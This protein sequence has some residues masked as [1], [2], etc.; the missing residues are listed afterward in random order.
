MNSQIKINTILAKGF[1]KEKEKDEYSL[2]NI[3]KEIRKK[4][5]KEKELWL[6]IIIKVHKNFSGTAKIGADLISYGQEQKKLG[7]NLFEIE[8]N[9][10][11]D[12]H[13]NDTLNPFQNELCIVQQLKELPELEE[14]I[15]D[16]I[17]YIIN[18][19]KPKDIE[20]ACRFEVV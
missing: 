6:Q 16:I 4:D 10:T 11:K 12:E 18:E 1:K 3:F 14:G 15:Y 7:K 13:A 9:I 17:T 2:F 20:D 8:I 19:G 5:I